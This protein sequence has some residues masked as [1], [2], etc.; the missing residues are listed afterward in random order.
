[1]SWYRVRNLPRVPSPSLLLYEGRL[2]A[3]LEQMLAIAGR[4]DRLRP[5][6]KTHKLPQILHKQLDLGI[7]KVKAAT[8]AEAEMAALS[9]VPDIMLAMQPAGANA[10]RWC[11]LVQRFP[12][13]NWT[14]LVDDAEALAGL[15]EAAEESDILLQTALDLNVGQNRT[16]VAPGPLATALYQQMSALG[17]IVPAGVHAYD[18]HVNQSD[19]A[20]RTAAAR[21]VSLQVME[22]VENLRNAGFEVPRVTLGGSPTFPIHAQLDFP[23]LELS[24]GTTVLWDAGYG[25]KLAEMPFQPAAMLVTRVVSKPQPDLLCLDLG[26]KSVGSEMAHPRAHFP[27]IPD[28]VAVTHN[29][30]HLV[31][32]TS[33]AAEF[34]VGDALY[35]MP[36]HICPTVA[37][38]SE[39]WLVQEGEVTLPWPVVGRARRLSI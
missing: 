37:L 31:I 25:K 36:Q 3:N 12:Q 34:S 23:G 21:A 33:Q 13:L 11:A 9:G 29:E 38:H 26:H 30:E 24:P 6:L 8:I 14:C 27:E 20:E 1:M 35:A 18:G 16:G 32:R 15:Q 17:N 28:A 5:H 19:A 7:R 22:V 10:W 2:Q 39:V 4:A